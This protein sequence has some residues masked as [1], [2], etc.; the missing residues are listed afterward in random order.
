MKMNYKHQLSLTILI[1]IIFNGLNMLLHHW[2]FTSIGR[3]L[4]GLLW[5]LHPV[6]IRDAV[7]NKRDKLIIRIAGAVLILYGI[8]GRL[9]L[10]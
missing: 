2:I 10:Y 8:F 7:P 1:L 3:C 9:Y 4:A 5:V 6:M